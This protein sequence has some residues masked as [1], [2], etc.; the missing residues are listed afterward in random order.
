MNRLDDWEWE[1]DVY[2]AEEASVTTALLFQ[3]A[4]DKEYAAWE[5]VRLQDPSEP[6]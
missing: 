1:W 6:E 5:T 4:A 2:Q 3:F